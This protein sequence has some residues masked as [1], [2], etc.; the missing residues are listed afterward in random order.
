MFQLIDYIGLGIAPNQEAIQGCSHIILALALKKGKTLEL[1]NPPV[2]SISSQGTGKVQ[3]ITD[4]SPT[5]IDPAFAKH[6]FELRI[7]YRQIPKG[8][9]HFRPGLTLI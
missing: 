1:I 3:T 2:C 8:K 6:C 5:Q 4:N 9:P 7:V